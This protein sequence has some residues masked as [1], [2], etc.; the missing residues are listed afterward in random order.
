[1]ARLQSFLIRSVGPKGGVRQK[2]VTATSKVQAAR[3]SG[4]FDKSKGHYELVQRPSGELGQTWKPGKT[5]KGQL[6]GSGKGG[7]FTLEERR[8]LNSGPGEFG[9]EGGLPR[10]PKVKQYW[11]YGGSYYATASG[12]KVKDPTIPK[13][14]TH[15]GPHG[16]GGGAG[17][18]P[19]LDE[20]RDEQGRWTFK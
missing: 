15:T 13:T 8:F 4:L 5:P 14:K 17:S 6:S 1:M 7:R 11:G 2:I 3:Q 10:A 9:S 12:R 20:P 18:A 19:W 16:R